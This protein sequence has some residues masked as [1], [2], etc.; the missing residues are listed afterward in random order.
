MVLLRLRYDTHANNLDLAVVVQGD[1]RL[2]GA[3]HEAIGLPRDANVRLVA[4]QCVRRNEQGQEHRLSTSLRPQ[5]DGLLFLGDGVEDGPP[6]EGG[7]EP[8][9]DGGVIGSVESGP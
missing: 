1:G 9:D 3:Q 5:K 8:D 6:S 7:S 2:A 4:C